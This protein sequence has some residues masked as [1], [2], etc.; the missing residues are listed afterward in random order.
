VAPGSP[1]CER[2]SVNLGRILRTQGFTGLERR[3]ALGAVANRAGRPAVAAA[4]A[5]VGV[6]AAR[7]P[8]HRG[9]E[10]PGLAAEF[11]HVRHGQDFYV[12]VAH[13]LDQFRRNDAGGA[14]AGR[15]GLVQAGHAAANGRA[16]FHE[17]NAKTGRRKVQRSLDAGDSAAADENAPVGVQSSTTGVS[18]AS[19]TDW[20]FCVLI[21][22]SSRRP[23]RP[24]LPPTGCRHW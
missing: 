1:S 24:R 13:A 10:A 7:T 8:L 3:G 19:V 22:L 12:E 14:V 15:E 9:L 23:H 16:L 4:G 2:V 11:D 5:L 21:F 17:I 18:V 6:H 20:P